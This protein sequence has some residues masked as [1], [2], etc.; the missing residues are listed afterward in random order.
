MLSNC[1]MVIIKKQEVELDSIPGQKFLL[2]FQ[3]L[4]VIL[5]DMV[6]H[7]FC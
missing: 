1:S 7:I 6:Y 4:V 3:N 5:T 2:F